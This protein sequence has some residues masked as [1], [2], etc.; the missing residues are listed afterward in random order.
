MI[1]E[2]SLLAQCKPLYFAVI[3]AIFSADANANQISE[4]ESLRT[5]TALLGHPTL[6]GTA[7]ALFEGNRFFLSFSSEGK[8]NRISIQHT[9][10]AV[11]RT[12]NFAATD[13]CDYLAPGR[14][15]DDADRE[16]SF[17]RGRGAARRLGHGPQKSARDDFGLDGT[18]A[19]TRHFSQL[20]GASI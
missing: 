20:D 17:I 2:Y 16:V 11:N 14:G 7:S 8:V 1:V 6:V 12:T 3:R 4:F 18:G 10:Y 5:G 15:Q 19:A 9:I 13:V